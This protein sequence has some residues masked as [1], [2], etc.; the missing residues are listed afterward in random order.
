MRELVNYKQKVEVGRLKKKII[1]EEFKTLKQ[2]SSY[3]V[4]VH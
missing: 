2:I 3:L 4:S 1:T